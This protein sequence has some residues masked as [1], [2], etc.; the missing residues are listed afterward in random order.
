MSIKK[1]IS[2]SSL[3]GNYYVGVAVG[4]YNSNDGEVTKSVT[5]NP[6]ISAV[7]TKIIK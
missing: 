5:Y 2:V 4:A 6:I 7:V 3:S 1:T